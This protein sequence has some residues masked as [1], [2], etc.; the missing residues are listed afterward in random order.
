MRDTCAFLPLDPTWHSCSSLKWRKL[1]RM[2][3]SFSF[4]PPSLPVCVHVLTLFFVSPV[5]E[6]MLTI[7][8]E[9][10]IKT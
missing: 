7:S 1:C 5:F 10:P 3:L 4:S 6:D 2:I 8:H 9:H